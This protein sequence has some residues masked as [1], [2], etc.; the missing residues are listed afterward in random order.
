MTAFPSTLSIGPDQL[1]GDSP[2]LSYEF[3]LANGGRFTI[4][5][6]LAPTIDFYS[7]GGLLTAI[8]IDNEPPKVL[9]IHD[10][11]NAYNWHRA[12]SE[13]VNV[14]TAS[15]DIPA[16]IH[17]LKVWRLDPGLVFEKILIKRAGV[18]DRTYL[19]PPPSF[20]DRAP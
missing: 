11:A 16:G 3:Y 12:V 17:S 19:G 8:S 14:V 20:L 15:T 5:L 7:K 4:E 1:S 2:H 9:N 18:E 6:L 13:Q 10:P